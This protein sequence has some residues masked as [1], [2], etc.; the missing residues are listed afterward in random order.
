[1]K[2]ECLRRF[3]HFLAF[4]AIQSTE[5]KQSHRVISCSAH[6][7]PLKIFK[8]VN[9]FSKIQF[10]ENVNA[11]G[12]YHLLEDVAV[13]RLQL[14]KQNHRIEP[15]NVHSDGLNGIPIRIR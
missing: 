3:H 5:S 1:M 6:R 14:Y 10:H 8:I 11:N 15:E 2:T 12:N 4:L 7:K 9:T 13:N